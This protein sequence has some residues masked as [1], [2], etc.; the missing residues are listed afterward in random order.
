MSRR[1]NRILL[2]V[3]TLIV[4]AFT[5]YS[6]TPVEYVQTDTVEGLPALTALEKLDV[7]GRAPK[8]GYEREQFGDGW[9][10]SNGCDVRNVILYRDLSDVVINE[11]CLVQSGTLNDPYT[12]ER[13]V[14]ERGNASAVQID[15]VVA[16]SDAW[17]KGAQLLSRSDRI[18]FANDPLNLLASDGPANQQK[19][20]GDAATWLPS[21]KP[22]RCLYVTRQI[23]V[24]QK[25]ALWVTEAESAAMRSVLQAC[26]QQTLPTP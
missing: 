11:A 15:H 5:A 2:W 10:E 25:Y 12:G 1:S 13:I 21:N 9:G 16:L 3:A 7:K 6:A 24:K 4:F 17:Q 26:P 22:F 14:F 20:D 23:A 19:G 18:R 8:T